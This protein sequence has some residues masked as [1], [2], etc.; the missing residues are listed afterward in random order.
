M[1][2]PANKQFR[3]VVE[4]EAIE[5]LKATNFEGFGCF[6]FWANSMLA[7]KLFDLRLPYPGSADGDTYDPDSGVFVFEPIEEVQ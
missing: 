4:G 2:R 7:Q 3:L 1:D 6:E 5:A